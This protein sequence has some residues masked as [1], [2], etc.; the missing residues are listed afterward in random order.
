MTRKHG[1]IQLEGANPS[2]EEAD[3]GT[4]EAVESGL[5]V[6]LNQRLMETGFKKSEYMAYLKTYV[7]A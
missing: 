3:E 6:V 4:D 7:K 2:A 5:D 1:D